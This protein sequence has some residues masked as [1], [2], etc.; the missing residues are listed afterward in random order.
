MDITELVFLTVIGVV[1]LVLI[2]SDRVAVERLPRLHWASGAFDR[3]WIPGRNG[4]S[5]SYCDEAGPSRRS[6]GAYRAGTAPA[7]AP[8]RTAG[9]GKNFLWLSS[10]PRA[11]GAD[12]APLPARISRRGAAPD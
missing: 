12:A 5:A 10:P 1:A 11:G 2:V 3:C 6:Q 9:T 4:K 8:E 7:Y